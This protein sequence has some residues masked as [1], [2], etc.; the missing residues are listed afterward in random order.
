MWS[1]CVVVAG[2]VSVMAAATAAAADSPHV[3]PLDTVSALAVAR[4]GEQSARF[5][6]LV[7]ELESSDVI[8]HVVA[9]P[10][11]PLGVIGTMRFVARL[12]DTRYIRIDLAATA[13][14]DLRVATLAHELQHACEVARSTAGSHDAVR[15]LYRRI[16]REVPGSR[17]AYETDGAR[18]IGAEVWTELRTRRPSRTTEQ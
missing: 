16:G 17:E 2:V 6:A 9:T 11:M 1:S 8:V 3:R 12:G 7:G 15:S 13:P 5:R 14:P 18:Q 4:G 10:S